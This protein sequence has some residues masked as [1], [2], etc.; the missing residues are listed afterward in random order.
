MVAIVS[1]LGPGLEIGSRAVLGQAGAQGDAAAGRNGQSVHVNVATG[2][3]VVQNQ[4]DYLAARGADHAIV[5][6]YNSAGMFDDDNGDQWRTASARVRLEG[7]LNAAGSA[8]HRTAADGST[9]IYSFDSGR[10]LYVTTAGAGAHDT[11]AYSAADAQFTWRDGDSGVT[12]RFEGSGAGRLLAS[13]DPAGNALTYAYGASGLLSSVTSS[14][15]DATFYDYEGANLMQVRTVAGGVTTSRVR[16]GYDTS[17]RLETV[18]VDLSPGDSVIAD[19]NVYQTRYGYEGSSRRLSQVTQADGSSLAFTYVDLGGGDH[20]VASI[21]NALGEVTTFSYGAGFSTVTDGLGLLTRY[22]FDI[23]GQVTRIATPAASGVAAERRFTYSAAGD[24]LTVTDGEGRITRHE[25]DANG[26]QVLQ[27]DAAG[28]T[29]RRTFDSAN[30]LLTETAYLQPDPDGAAAGQPAEPLT[31]RYAYDV[32]GRN[33]LRFV[34]GADGGVTEHRY[35]GFGERTETITYAVGRFPVTGLA[36]EIAPPEAELQAWAAGQPASSMPRLTMAYDG[37]GQLQSRTA[38][39]DGGSSIER[40][41]YDQAGQL[42]QTI[43]A[44]GAATSYSYDGLGRLLAR[45]DALGHSQV[46][47]YDDAGRRTLVTLAG[48]LIQTSAYDAAGRLLS[49]TQSDA[50]G[51]HLG[52][53]RYF[54]DAAGRLRMVRDP[55]GVSTTYFHDEAGRKVAEVDGNGTLTEHAY[56]RAGQRV[57]TRVRATAVDVGL[58]VDGSGS[59]RLD[60]TLALIRPADNPGDRATWQEYDA[61]GRLLRQAEQTGSGSH[62]AVTENRHDGAGRLVQVVRYAQTITVDA[63]GAL[64]PGRVP[65]PVRSG[66]DRVTRHFHDAEGRLAGILD[67]EG[68]LTALHYTAA[69]QLQERLT[70]ATPTQVA[71]RAEAALE[72]LLP[73]GSPADRR[74]FTLYDGQGRPVAQVDAEGYL[75]ETTYDAAG[76]VARNVRY[77]HRVT[78][79]PAAAGSVMEL[80]PPASASDRVTE[81]EYDALGRLVQ[82]RD[83]D[84]VVTRHGYDAQGRLVATNRAVGTGEARSVLARHDVQG[85]LVGELSGEG[86]ALIT[87]DQTA[88]QVEAIWMAHGVRHTYDAAGRRTSTVDALGHRTLFF[89]DADGAQTHV[90]NALGEV[91]EARYDALGRVTAQVAYAGRIETAGLQGG[92]VTQSL[93]SALAVVA[94]PARD[95]CTTFTY[96]SD[97]RV[98]TAA[99]AQGSLQTFTH[100]AFGEVVARKHAGHG[101]NVLEMYAFDRLGRRVLTASDAT[102]LNAITSAV[103]DAF[104][105]ITR[106]VAANGAIREYS[107]DRLGRVIS[108]RDPLDAMRSSSYD[109]F[110]RVLTQTDGLGHATSYAYDP[111]ARSMTVTTPEGVA[112]TTTYNAHGQVRSIRDGAGE[113]TSYVY[114]HDGR[115]I[116]TTTPLSASS[117]VHDAAGRLMEVVDANGD[118]VR[119]TYDAA[120]RVLTRVV[121]PDGLA[122]ATTY[123]YDGR[124]QRVSTT[125]PAGVVTAVEY[126]SRGQVIRQTVDPDGLQL[127]TTYTYDARGNILEV[128]SPGGTLT[129]YAFDALGRRVSE[130][131][132]PDGL[133]LE[134]RWTYDMAGNVT[135]A[136]DSRGSVTRY[137]Y[138]AADRLVFTVDPAGGVRQDSHDAEGRVTKTTAYAAPISLESLPAAL[139]ASDVASR[140]SARPPQDQVEHRI[141]DRDGRVAATVDGLGA[142]VRYSYDTRGS[143]VERVAHASLADLAAWTPGTIPQVAADPTVD[144]R[145]SSIHDALGR[146]LYSV[147]GTG[148]VVGYVYDGEGRVLQRTAYAIAIG[149]HVE[150]SA[151]GIE[152]ALAAVRDPSRDALSQHA[153]DT[154]GRLAWSVDGAGAVT[155]YVRDANG[156]V[157]RQVRY[158]VPVQPGTDP[159]SVVPSDADRASSYAYDAANR[160]VMEVS[161][162]GAVTENVLDAE[163]RPV[164]RIAYAATIGQPTLG[165]SAEGIRAELTPDAE[166]DRSSWHGYDAAGRHVLTV[167]PDGSAIA[168]T[169]D[170]AGNIVASTAYAVPMAALDLAG[171]VPL[172]ALRGLLMASSADRVSRSA[173]DAAGRKVYEVDA[174]GAVKGFTR[175]ALGRLLQTRSYALPIP[176]SAADDVASALVASTADR[177][178]SHTYDAAGNRISTRDALGGTE[179]WRYDALGRKTAFINKLGAEWNYRYDSG[180]R[181]V[182]EM[183]PLVA[184]TTSVY[185]ETART[186]QEGVTQQARVTTLLAYD[187]IGN[188]VRRT[189]AAGRQGEERTTRYEYDAA[190]RQVRVLHP[191]VRVHDAANDD[192]TINSGIV[193]RKEVER[194]LETR[195]YYNAFGEAVANIDVGGG[196]SQKVYDAA[197]RLVYD[198]DALGFVTGYGYGYGSFGEAAWLTRH[199]SATTLA[200]RAMANASHAASALEVQSAL[201]GGPSASQDRSLYTTYDRMGRALETG[202]PQGFVHDTTLAS[203]QQFVAGA[204]TRNSYNAFGELLQV[205]KARDATG[206][207]WYLTTH[208]FDVLGRNTATVDAMGYLT[209]RA[210]DTAGNLVES[211]EYAHALSA[212][213]W[214]S[215]SHG[216][217][218]ASSEDRLTRYGYD[219]LQRKVSET[220]VDVEFSTTSDGSAARGDLTTVYAFDALGNQTA[221]TDALGQTTRTYYDALGHVR[222]VAAPLVAGGAGALKVFRRDAH[223]NSVVQ[224]EY[225]TPMVMAEGD[226]PAPEAGASDRVT[227]T[228][229]DAMGR[230]LA[231]RDANSNLAFSSFDERGNVVKSWRGVTDANGVTRSQFQVNVYD[232]LGR[233]VGTQ[234]PASTTVL[235]GGLKATYTP[236][237]SPQAGSAF[238]GLTTNKLLLEWSNL[239]KVPG[240]LVRISVDYLTRAGAVTAP[241]GD[242]K[243]VP[244]R[245]ET[246]SRQDTATAFAGGTELTWSVETERVEQ[247]RVE[248]FEGG[249]WKPLWQGALAK[250]SG[251]GIVTLT[252][253]E[254]GVVH[255]RQEFNAFGEMTGRGTGGELQEYF[256]YNSAGR[257]WRTNSGDGVDRVLLHDLH[258]NVTAEIRSAGAGGT[259]RDVLDYASAQAAHADP[260]A[261]RVDLKYNALGQLTSRAE[262][263]RLRSDGAVVHVQQ[264]ISAAI[265]TSGQAPKL[266]GDGAS[267]P[268]YN[269]IQ[270]T[271]ERLRELGSGDIRLLVDYTTPVMQQGGLID[272]TGTRTPITFT[273]GAP[274]V[275]DSGLVIGDQHPSGMLL[276]WQ[277]TS[278]DHNA[279]GIGAITRVRLL[280]KDIHGV[281]HTLFDQEPGR[282]AQEIRIEAPADPQAKVSLETLRAGETTWRTAPPGA[283][284][285]F[286]RLYR[287]DTTGLGAG[288]YQYRVTVL[289]PGETAGSV[290]STGFLDIQLPALAAITTPISYGQATAMGSSTVFPTMVPGALSWAHQSSQVLQEFRY[291]LAG[292]AQAW[293]TL[294]VQLFNQGE[295]DGVNCTNL[296]AATYEFELLWSRAGDGYPSSHATGNFTVVA[297][298]PA[299]LVPQVGLPPITGL[300]LGTM[301]TFDFVG[302]WVTADGERY[303][304][305]LLWDSVGANVCRYYRNGQ[306]VNL[307]INNVLAN[308]SNAEERGVQRAGLGALGVGTHTIEVRRVGSSNDLLGT[309]R[310]VV[311]SNGTRSL[312]NITPPWSPAYW[313]APVPAQYGV[314]LTTAASGP[315]ISTL[316]GMGLTLSGA[317]TT[318]GQWL[319]PTVLQNTDRWGNVVSITDP[320]SANWV[321]TYRF[322]ANNQVVEQ[323]QPVA[324][325]ELGAPVTTVYFDALGRQ[326][327]VRDANGNVNGQAFDA[328]GNLVEER[329]ADGGVIRHSYDALGRRT[330]TVDALGNVVGFSYDAMGNLLST[331][332]GALH[333]YAYNGTAVA[334]YA[335]EQL[336]DRWTYDQLGQKL[337]HTNG[338]GEKLTFVYDLRGN[339]VETRQPLGQRTR[340]A[341]DAMGRKTAEVDANSMAA[342]WTYDYFGR[343]RDHVDL[344]GARYTYTYDNAWQLVSQSSTRMQE[345]TFGYDAAGQLTKITDGNLAQRTEYRYDE[346]GRRILERVVQGDVAYQENHLGYDAVGNLRDVADG[347]VHLSMKY[348]RV[349]NR[350]SVESYVNYGGADGQLLTQ[351]AFRFF[352]YD[353]MNRQTVV[354]GTS[355]AGAI[356]AGQGHEIT[357]DKNGNRTSDRTGRNGVLST[358]TYRYDAA[359]RIESVVRDGVTVENRHYD[360]A[361]R[362]VKT[363]GRYNRYDANGRLLHQV[364]VDESGA[365]TD[366]SWDEQANIEGFTPSG[367][368]GVGN[369]KGYVV[370]GASGGVVEY[371]MDFVRFEGHQASRTQVTSTLQT[372]GSTTYQYDANGFLLGI[373]DATQGA[374]NRVFVNDATGK[375]LFVN[376]QGRI[377]RQLVVNGEVLGV[378]GAAVDREKPRDANDN[379]NFVNLVDFSFGYAPITPTYP[380]PSPGTYIVQPGDTLQSVAKAAYGDSALWYRIAEANGL[381][382]S[383]DLKVGQTLH[384]PNRVSTIHNNDGTFKPYDPTRV[385]GDVT[386]NLPMPEGGCGGVGQLL[387]VIVAIVVTIYSAGLAAGAFAPAGA[388]AAPWA[389]GLA[390]LAG[391]SAGGV[392]I[393][394]TATVVGA[395]VGGAAGS[396]ASQL[397]GNAAGVI[398]GFSWKNVAL[399]AISAGATAGVGAHVLASTGVLSQTLPA[400]VGRALAANVA[401]QGIAVALGLQKRFDWRGVAASG[402]GAAVGQAIGS[403]IG[404]PST[405]STAGMLARATA[406]GL[407]GGLA[408]AAARGGRIVVQ[409]IAVDAFGNAL[410]EGLAYSSS[411]IG[412]SSANPEIQSFVDAVNGFSKAGAERYPGVNVADFVRNNGEYVTEHGFNVVGE[413]TL[414]DAAQIPIGLLP[415]GV[416]P[417]SVFGARDEAGS[418]FYV[419]QMPD[420]KDVRKHQNLFFEGAQG[421]VAQGQTGLDSGAISPSQYLEAVR[422]LN[423][424]GAPLSALTPQFRVEVTGVGSAEPGLSFQEVNDQKV[425]TGNYDRYREIGQAWAAGNVSEMWRHITFEASPQ[426]RDAAIQR[427]FPPQHPDIVR[428]QRMADSP[429]GAIASSVGRLFGANQQR[430]DAL[431]MTGGLVERLGGAGSQVYKQTLTAP[432]PMLGSLASRVRGLGMHP[433]NPLD[434][435]P[436]GKQAPRSVRDGMSPDHIPS[437]AAIRMH[438]ERT[439]NRPLTFREEA[440]L[441]NSTTTLMIDTAMHQQLSRTYGGRNT[442][443][444]VGRDSQDLYSAAMR[445]MAAYRHSLR[446]RGYSE[447][448]IDAAFDKIHTANK[449]RGLY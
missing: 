32:T 338:N 219:M 55:S 298:K 412:K 337:T 331:D 220:R 115:L 52:E 150:R 281:F 86:A 87:G 306:W 341:F 237:L 317:S 165:A 286:G 187:A 343:L 208:Y 245:L 37:R 81:R 321:T 268:R 289:R 276:R 336:K 15:G 445:D 118:R 88:E 116:Q 5:R 161:A 61:A 323:K 72:A 194:A 410:G 239:V 149:A 361:D 335:Y 351:Q 160:L 169:L 185:D 350:T 359:S 25:Y 120:D 391:G 309:V 406:V 105:Q 96:T 381:A 345:L 135:T 414:V 18:T 31:T 357:Y 362:L 94:D 428:V 324:A 310:Y 296:A 449:E 307:T 221:V 438:M 443:M 134:R 409:Q 84:G 34:V 113:I 7:A 184:L 171:G 395:T 179:S 264:A 397:V 109:A 126:D 234:T 22:E 265:V 382:T 35:N 82:E 79:D 139:G 353:A 38:H 122:L 49:I 436:Y 64:A 370:R 416:D 124:G 8:I 255:T 213:T 354:D 352:K 136:T 302:S 92:L 209:T 151:Q 269:E 403:G 332:K 421:V 140:V 261:R 431:L 418:T 100:N 393:G 223:G 320:R 178:E 103:Y 170:A 203:E 328:G 408:A 154:A 290:I 400:V 58:L 57:G 355:A 399:S 279:S 318:G 384:I 172:E 231:T 153:Y 426:A 427:S 425:T 242:P 218:A 372:I 233:L 422:F 137:V 200:T 229:F 66:D 130:R 311:N 259:D 232:A 155:R 365:R 291:R 196:L 358:E 205:A 129:R 319:R 51:A 390:A 190:G 274:K 435:G 157:V 147:D 107:H 386:P 387:M 299:V 294:P 158:A 207:S 1:G 63:A 14:S 16:Y 258:G 75:T 44:N 262:A 60:V 162:V 24:V 174:S 33:L 145:S 210:Y 123:A 315:A 226:P 278:T 437:F 280:K 21:R 423:Q 26:N 46:T 394:A 304:H 193:G 356:S 121:D 101:V 385:M 204:R 374:N 270:F 249:K 334:S 424:S 267:P 251:S 253:A 73:Q 366:V 13:V 227:L 47:R 180:G 430:Q 191:P 272:E 27:Q 41:V 56:D 446:A 349:G 377:E 222:A 83:P 54:H 62:A 378:Y 12:Q 214:N 252:Q 69:G 330:R 39:S 95:A 340:A 256:H 202:Q 104:G 441:R 216:T 389:T 284:V 360:G 85:R 76:N 199:A 244:S 133:N 125:D 71:L 308:P 217:P 152:A 368:D 10:G 117:N 224:V 166:R 108:T 230:A 102:G 383:N 288:Q 329:H 175:D 106:S 433:A 197:G 42:L 206:S 91:E 364:I 287:Y 339:V 20:R 275:Y 396:I 313:T 2:N 442:P 189:E 401:T 89:Y 177:I 295:R 413:P 407:V 405:M 326:V 28:H 316:D 132:D 36:P 3:L 266:Q 260:N 271:W 29:V 93:V 248:Q 388:A 128:V 250:A 371:S 236:A 70:Y 376:Q 380:S 228:H 114:D 440:E 119:Y 112:T 444:Q 434:V 348:D 188:L 247:I 375:A 141:H 273:G 314:S 19:G 68:H 131:V 439:L 45:T 300:R 238:P 325:P 198:V 363:T 59:P 344:G 257:L 156:N 327:A 420:G 110:S 241:D 138:D 163:G 429:I 167:R 48:G 432:A 142:V 333:V 176:A 346:A 347:R 53:T 6:T 143:L 301:L 411:G 4:D 283:L 80:R 293:S 23:R 215:S 305:A 417:S 78:I 173:Y 312:T 243:F 127:Q 297:A 9:A 398:D 168:S 182:E 254:A 282:G 211:K 292:S 164:R 11:I 97:G 181:L 225:V 419:M 342:T 50:S 65:V 201:A 303:V 373:A 447:Q 392:T 186:L 144:G 99:D 98:A 192:L 263:P 367:Y 43:A 74:E 77:A 146:L 322:N 212:G 415:Q 111:A 67:A 404:S 402:I 379:P 148:A 246:V 369:V 40:F 30:R 90:V 183:S 159:S 17:N 235:Q 277:E 285:D 195:T 448:Q 240:G